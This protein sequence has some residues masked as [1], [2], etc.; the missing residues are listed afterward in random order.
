M[1][2]RRIKPKDYEKVKALHA[3]SPAKYELPDF[4]GKNFIAGFVAVDDDDNPR[5]LLCFRRTAEA[6]VV[7][8]HEYDGPAYR[9]V[10]LGELVENAKAV[11]TGLGYD[12]AIGTIGPDVPKSY[13][14]RLQRFGCE[15]FE[16]WTIVKMLK[17]A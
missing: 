17:G 13:L 11:M 1:I 5:V 6:Y 10:A 8:D 14:R 12:D 15:V 16:N 3:Q 2:I 7:V 9:L 4:A